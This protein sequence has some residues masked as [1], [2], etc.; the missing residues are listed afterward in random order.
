MSAIR[1]TLTAGVAAGLV[2][3]ATGTAAVSGPVAA[4]ALR[5]VA[6]PAIQLSAVIE[7][8]LQPVANVGGETAAA[9]DWIINVYNTV[10]PWVEYGV[11]LAAWAVSWLPWPIGLIGPQANIL[12]SGWQPIG[13]ALAYDAAFLLDRQFDLIIPTLVNG[14]KTGINDLVRGEIDWVLSFF[15]PL[16]PVSVPVLPVL[17][18][19][20]GAGAT[21]LTRSAAAA[22]PRGAATQTEPVAEI[23]VSVDLAPAAEAEPTRR[24]SRPLG[25]SAA[26]AQRAVPAP[27]AVTPAPAAT[28]DNEAPAA[29]AATKAADAPKTNAAKAT[30]AAKAKPGA[31]ASTRTGRAGR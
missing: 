29:T 6:S 27:P 26:R 2:V 5:S 11:N 16:P 8:L 1:S 23:P 17:P 21:T 20:P 15:P 9:G 22:L 10:Q 13:Q 12:Y 24:A 25:R 4:P 14:L 31:A 7:P 30:L 19:F 28:V 3:A 18:S